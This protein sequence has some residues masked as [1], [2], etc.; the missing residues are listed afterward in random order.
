M[1]Q[2]DTGSCERYP[3]P[4]DGTGGCDAGVYHRRDHGLHRV[5]REGG[6]L[7][8]AADRQDDRA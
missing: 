7:Y 3:Y 5:N 4:F 6:R 2:C 8:I 1:R